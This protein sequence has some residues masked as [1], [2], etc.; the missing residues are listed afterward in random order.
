MGS[1]MPYLST[2]SE[3][4]APRTQLVSGVSMC[5]RSISTAV[6]ALVALAAMDLSPTAIANR[7]HDDKHWV[8][9]W[10]A[11]PQMAD[12]PIHINGQTLRQIVHT[13]VGGEG[14]RV[15][16][17]NAY[18]TSP[19]VIGAAHVAVSAGGA[20]IF[21]RTDRTLK[22][23]GSPTVA[24]P[25]GAV[26]VS[27]AVTL[28]VSAL[29]DLAVS[30]YLPENVT[31]NT[32]HSTSLQT[33]YLSAAG[34]FTGASTVSGT[35]TQAYY[36]L[37]GVEVGGSRPARAIVTLGDSVTDGFGSTPDMN[38]R[39]PNLLAERLQPHWRGSGVAV[40]NAG[41]SGNRVLHDFVGT[42][43]AARLDRDVLVQTG[44]RYL[45]LLEGN[46][47]ILIPGLIGNPAEAVT[48]E[49]IIQ[50]HRQIIARAHAAGLR[51]YGGTLNPVEG[52]P[53]PGFWTTAMEEK[54]QAVNRWIRRGTAYDGVIDFDKVLRDPLHPTR[55]LPDYDSGDHVHPNDLGYRVM[56]DAIELT[57]FSDD[58][59]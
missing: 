53:F 1:S 13:S 59:D 21:G 42:S 51:V 22:F 50:G 23:S 7:R 29:S 6:V 37:A 11:S 35:T 48:A 46:A 36:F 52:Y 30:L 8:A 47:D 9:T 19:L 40:L 14:V 18:G 5:R 24:I 56:A 28:E 15:R 55:L 58:D 17:S 57:L 3:R 38:Q 4:P 31:A 20:S 33:T 27:D 49:Q 44:A 26:A 16:V 45:I 41:I 25:S 12:V 54:R 10:S 43:A 2:R 39:W 32:E 34:N